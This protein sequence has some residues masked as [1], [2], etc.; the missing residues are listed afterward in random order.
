LLPVLAALLA[1]CTKAGST[2]SAEDPVEAQ[3]F[4]M[5]TVITQRVYGKNASEAVK[6]VADKLRQIETMMTVNAPGG[7]VNH[8]NSEAGKNSVKLSS[9]TL[10]VL[11]KAKKYSELSGGA[12]DVTIG[13]LVKAWGVFT[14]NPRVPSEEEIRSLLPLVDYRAISIDKG[15]S[16]AKLEKAGQMVDLGGI[17]K[18]YAGDEAI[19]I[20]KKYGIKSAYVNLGGNVVAMGSKPDGTPW[21]IG[22]QNPRAPSGVYMGIVTVSDK[23]VVTSGDYERF[24]EQ[25]NKRYHHILDPKTGYPSASGLISSTIIADASV[26]ADALST[27]TFVLGLEKGMK[28]VESLDGVEAVFITEDKKVYTTSGLKGIFKLVDESKEFTYVEER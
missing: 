8:L 1:G 28:L 27:A 7:D 9:E 12:F 18:G 16:S 14:D 20:Y 6:E 25:D 3:D 10:Y 5:G 11:E 4:M 19:K 22:I 24:F 26:D 2:P 17:A 13:P 15:D 23:A 21:R